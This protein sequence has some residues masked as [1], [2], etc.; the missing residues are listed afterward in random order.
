MCPRPHYLFPDRGPRHRLALDRDPGVRRPNGRGADGVSSLRSHSCTS[1]PW[2]G[3]P[4]R[5]LQALIWRD[6]GHGREFPPGT[7][8]KPDGL[9]FRTV[10]CVAF[11]VD[12]AVMPCLVLHVPVDCRLPVHDMGFDSSRE[13]TPAPGCPI[14]LSALFCGASDALCLQVYRVATDGGSALRAGSSCAWQRAFPGIAPS[15]DSTSR[16]ASRSAGQLT[17]VAGPLASR[18]ARQPGTRQ[19]ARH[20]GRRL[21]LG[22]VRHLR[23]VCKSMPMSQE[24]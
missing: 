4:R 10:D 18:V 19:L 11:H 6:L 17:G 22:C 20:S 7:A 1:F 24:A 8:G 13:R 12:P 14:T 5:A 9:P 23:R 15:A 2:F 3:N 21:P 16:P